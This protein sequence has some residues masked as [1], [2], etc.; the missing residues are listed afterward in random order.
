MMNKYK[1]FKKYYNIYAHC[2]EAKKLAATKY[3]YN[4]NYESQ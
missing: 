4:N 2:F 1:I 3:E